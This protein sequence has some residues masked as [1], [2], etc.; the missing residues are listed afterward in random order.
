[1]GTYTAVEATSERQCTLK[2]LG[3]FSGIALHTGTRAHLT[4]R[5]APANTGIVFS[6]IDVPGAPRVRAFVKN[7]VDVNRATTLTDGDATIHTVEHVLAALYACGV[8]NAIVDIDGPEPPI[9]DGS[10]APYV[11]LIRAAGIVEQEALRRCCII[12]EPIIAATGSVTTLIVPHDR[13]R[14]TCTVQ[15]GAKD[16][17][18]QHGD[19]EVT[20]ESFSEELAMA[21]TFCPDYRELESL[22]VAGLI[23]GASLDNAM[24]LTEN[25]I[26]SKDGLRYPDELVRHKMLDIVGDLSLIG[27]RLVG[28]VVAV[29]PGHPTNVELARKIVDA[30]GLAAA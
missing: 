30:M 23:R 24:V 17:Y 29:K 20:D 8:D 9:A 14:I 22:M 18:T 26:I 19:L 28:M 13:Y 21:R 10:S 1:M 3:R 27:C 4:I 2:K 12:R 6:R 11:Q 16:V 15:Y 5:P 25:A 7:V